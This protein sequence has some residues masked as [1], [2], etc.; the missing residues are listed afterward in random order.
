MG[1]KDKKEKL[2]VACPDV[3]SELCNVLIYNGVQVL[4]EDTIIPGPTESI[5]FGM[6][7]ELHSQIQDYSMLRMEDGVILGLYTLENQS[8]PDIR[9]PLR[10]A[11]YEGAAYRNQFHNGK[12]QGIYPVVSI[13]L[14]WGEQPWKY[15]TTIKE[16]IDYPI[17]AGTEKYIN[18]YKCHVFD[19]TYAFQG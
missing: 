18:D 15:A 19:V 6:D 9:M 12:G 4:S 3:F 17:P 11:G 1:Q 13:V 5:Y 8:V 16:L 2:F 14:N 7:E 10:N